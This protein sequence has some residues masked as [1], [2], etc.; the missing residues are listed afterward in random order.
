MREIVPR[1]TGP[2]PAR[3]TSQG[4]RTSRRRHRPPGWWG[5]PGSRRR[6][7]QRVGGAYVQDTRL[8]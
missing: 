5:R 7:R 6:Y 2:G 8:V 4:R 1:D 3:I